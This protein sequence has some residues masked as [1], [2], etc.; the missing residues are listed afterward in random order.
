MVDGMKENLNK[1]KCMAKGREFITP[2]IF[3]QGNLKKVRGKDKEEWN[4]KME[5]LIKVDEEMKKCMDKEYLLEV[6]MINLLGD[7]RII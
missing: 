4:F 2:G 7:L 5:T 3:T 6:L 1:V